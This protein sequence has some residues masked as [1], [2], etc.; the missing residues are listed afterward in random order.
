[1]T[2]H[3]TSGIQYAKQ[4]IVLIFF[5]KASL[6]WCSRHSLCTR[7]EFTLG[8]VAQTRSRHPVLVGIQWASASRPAWTLWPR[9]ERWT[10]PHNSLGAFFRTDIGNVAKELDLSLLR[11]AWVRSHFL[12]F[13]HSYIKPTLRLS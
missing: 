10:R 13:R 12:I 9:V 3:A 7:N 5:S 6:S 8:S 2:S 1:M 11:D 4:C